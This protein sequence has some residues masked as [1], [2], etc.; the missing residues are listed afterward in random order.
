M[1]KLDEIIENIKFGVDYYPEHWPEE[2]WETDAEL[3]EKMGIQMVR[4][5][6]FSWHKMEPRCGE[7]HFE[8]LDRAVNLLGRHGIYTMLGTPTAAPPAWIVEKNPEILPVDSNGQRKSFGGRHHDCQSNK[9]YRE[10]VKRIVA[11]M[12]EHFKNNPYIIGWQID[13]ELGNSHDD[14]CMC[15]SCKNAFSRW[16]EN[17]YHTIDELNHQWGTS[18]WSQEYDGFSQIPVPRKTPTVHNP[19]MLLDWK[20]FCSDLVID[21]QNMQI[22]IIRKISPNQKITHNLMGFYDKTNY[23]KM[24]ETLDF[25]ANDQYPTGYYFKAPGQPPY[26]VAACMDFIRCVK[27]KNFWMMEMQSGPTG[28]SVIGANPRP[29]QNLLWTAQSVAHGA[30]EITYFRWRTCLFGAEQFWHGI[31]PHNGVP[32]R[33]YS[34]IQETIQILTPVMDDIHGIVQKAQA[35]I[36]FS[37]ENEWA[38]RL[39]PQNPGLKYDEVVFKYYKEFYKHN[40]TV[41]FVASGAD[42]G[43]Y[44]IL[45]APLLYLMTPE[46]EK[47]LEKYVKDGGILILTMRTGVMNN[48]NVCMSENPLPGKLAAIVGAKVEEYDSLYEKNV[49]LNMKDWKGIGEHW[50]D[51]LSPASAVPIAIYGSEYYKGK[52]AIVKNKYKNGWVYYIGTDP[53]EKTM[54]YLMEKILTD[55]GMFREKTGNVEI[56]FRKGRKKEYLFVMNHAEEDCVAEVPGGWNAEERI[57]LKGYEVKILERNCGNDKSGRQS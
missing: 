10:H 14:L 44:R 2:R 32:G 12:A 51:I 6:E 20:R 19:S 9:V 28:G 15:E 53:E 34:E 52:A 45:V 11:A 41:D 33:R 26:E 42:L 55:A 49:I 23:F 13:N 36:L 5:A 29:G 56:V 31:L 7:F 27:Q 21:F 47:R 43:K 54:E 17:K 24:A 48:N 30:D 4:M 25:A 37:Y 16:L 1:K 39:Q 46:L 3:M 22:S 35:G 40:I 50:C 57:Q 38:I 18:F 8:W